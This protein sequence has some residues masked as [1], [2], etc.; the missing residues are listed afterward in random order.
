[1]SIFHAI[2]SGDASKV[3]RLL[4]TDPS[5]LEGANMSRGI[6]G[7]GTTP[8]IHAADMGQ[9]EIVKLL[10][11]KGANI[12]ATT[13]R[14]KTALH[15]ATTWGREEVV[16]HLLDNGARTSDRDEIGHTPL[17]LAAR[18][19][20]PRVALRLLEHMGGAL[21]SFRLVPT[22]RA[23]SSNRSPTWEEKPGSESSN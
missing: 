18:I 10:T 3:M 1:M 6:W 11:A 9:L 16:A 8:L 23:T 20:R 14:A 17:M 4:N 13:S 12:H 5:L 2:D 21:S 22:E 7:T 15:L 19:G